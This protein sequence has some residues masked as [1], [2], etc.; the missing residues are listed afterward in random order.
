M[1]RSVCLFVA[2]R[3][4][5][6]IKQMRTKS[7]KQSIVVEERRSRPDE[8]PLS[9]EFRVF[10]A[11]DVGQLQVTSSPHTPNGNRKQKVGNRKRETGNETI[12]FWL[13]PQTISMIFVDV[14]RGTNIRF[15]A[16]SFLIPSHSR[17]SSSSS[18]SSS[19][20]RL[21]L[22]SLSPSQPD[23]GMTDLLP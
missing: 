12:S 17:S 16:S 3:Y 6:S 9:R 18:S 2:V 7:L 11:R 10:W 20:R 22:L 13:F 1:M 4:R 8:P 19:S 5:N 21:S 15:C 23:G 14:S